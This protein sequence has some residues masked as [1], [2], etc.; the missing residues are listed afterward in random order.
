METAKTIKEY[1]LYINKVRE[2]KH[3]LQVRVKMTD[4]ELNKRNELDMQGV[5]IIVGIEYDEIRPL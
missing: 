4:E 1:Q 5:D 2:I 3:A